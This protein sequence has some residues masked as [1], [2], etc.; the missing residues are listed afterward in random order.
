MNRE[1][2]DSFPDGFI[3]RGKYGFRKQPWVHAL[4]VVV[5]FAMVPWF[6]W[7]PNPLDHD[8]RAVLHTDPATLEGIPATRVV[9]QPHREILHDPPMIEIGTFMHDCQNCHSLFKSLPETDRRLGEKLNQHTDIVLNH[10][11]NDRCFNCHDIDNRNKLVLNG[12]KT[13]GYDNVEILCSKCHGPTYRDWQKGIHG[14]VDGYWNKSKGTPIHRK[15]TECHNPHSPAFGQWP[16]MP[17]PH[18]LRVH[19]EDYERARKAEEEEAVHASVH[20]PLRQWSVTAE[21]RQAVSG[22]SES[23]DQSVEESEDEH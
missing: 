6:L 7:G 12:G 3:Q 8:A 22:P 4:I 14:R 15:C 1:G 20:I 17:G 5:F 9:V 10:G 16:L 21:E 2:P 13:I 11:M 18:S 23:S 19:A